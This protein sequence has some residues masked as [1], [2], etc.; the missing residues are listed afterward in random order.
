MRRID[1]VEEFANSS[2][3]QLVKS[4]QLTH[5]FHPSHVP[6]TEHEDGSDGKT[7]GSMIGKRLI[8]RMIALT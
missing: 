5:H 7:I 4:F 3:I 2:K 1:T 8:S 6:D